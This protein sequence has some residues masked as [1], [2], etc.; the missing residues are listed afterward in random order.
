MRAVRG[1]VAVASTPGQVRRVRILPAHPQAN[2]NALAA[3]SDAD[4]ITIGP[5]SW[6]SSVLPHVLVPEIV[7]TV[8]SSSAMRVVVLNL[9]A[10]PGETQGFSAERHLHV[11]AQHAPELRIDRVLVDSNAI[12]SE[13]ERSYLQRAANV[14]GAQAVFADVS[15]RDENGVR[16]NK[17][18]PHKLSAA[19]KGLLEQS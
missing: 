2:P 12:P 10:E 5:G 15:L 17:H 4:L 19:L 3:L 1:Q 7:N 18:D 14:L 11:L 16:L 8:K 13:S 9:S 6:F